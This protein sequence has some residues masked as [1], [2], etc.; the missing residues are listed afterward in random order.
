ML[1]TNSHAVAHPAKN[2]TRPQKVPFAKRSVNARADNEQSN[3]K[4]PRQSPVS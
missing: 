4:L 2:L 1:C 3:G